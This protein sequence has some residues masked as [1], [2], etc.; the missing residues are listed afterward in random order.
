MIKKFRSQSPLRL[1]IAGGGS[2]VS[3]YS[4][5]H[6]GKIVNMTIDMY[7]YC[8][9]ELL[10]T[11]YVELQALDLKLTEKHKI[12]KLEIN[13]KLKLHKAIYNKICS[14]FLN[15]NFIGV[16]ILTYSDAPPGSG[17]GSSSS[18]VVAILS[19]FKKALKLPLGSYDLAHLA[20][21]IERIDCEETGGKQDQYAATFGGINFMEFY[22]NDRVIVNPLEISEETRLE[23]QSHIL[24]YFTNISRES[25]N[26][27]KNQIETAR[28]NKNEDSSLISM[29][30]IKELAI[31][32]KEYLLNGDILN[33][34]IALKESWIEK[35]KLSSNISN[36]IIEDATDV[37][38][39]NGANSVKVTG[40]GGGGFIMIMSDPNYHPILKYKL[41]KL[42]GYTR[43]IQITNTGSQ[44]WKVE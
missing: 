10:D 44:A 14:F 5:I 27:I 32:T 23:L 37:A 15:N 33:I 25:K 34:S 26:I 4:D 40:A 18:M 8:T 1:G 16:K 2:D 19:A 17:L 35:K 21:E 42:G 28:S 22:C 7:T 12:E 36:Q 41:N 24:L 13:G 30:K 9:I 3:P 6:G 11:N 20:F 29:H 38:F 39:Q 43:K 31:K